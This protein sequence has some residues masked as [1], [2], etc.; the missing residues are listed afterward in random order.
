M[1]VDSILLCSGF[2]SCNG[3]RILGVEVHAKNAV[4]KALLPDDRQY[5]FIQN[6]G[7]APWAG[8][9]ILK[10]MKLVSIVSNVFFKL[11]NLSDQISMGSSDKETFG[12]LVSKDETLNF[13]LE[14]L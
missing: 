9:G 13:K 1:S 2:V 6:I 7:D 10:V 5:V 3:E 8:K 12:Y 4:V 14:L 11:K